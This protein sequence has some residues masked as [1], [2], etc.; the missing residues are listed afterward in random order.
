MS[1]QNG[2]LAREMNAMS[3]LKKNTKKTKRDTDKANFAMMHFPNEP[4]L[5]LFLKPNTVVCFD[6]TLILFDPH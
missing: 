1:V 4:T 5:N 2:L 6:G 3:C